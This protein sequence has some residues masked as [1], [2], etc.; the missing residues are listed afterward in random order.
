[1]PMEPKELDREGPGLGGGDTRESIRHGQAKPTRI[2]QIS[3]SPNKVPK[4]RVDG[5][6]M[7]GMT[8][9]SGVYQRDGR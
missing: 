7:A 2:Q 1:M 9:E 5:D 4:K 3:K 6:L 8:R